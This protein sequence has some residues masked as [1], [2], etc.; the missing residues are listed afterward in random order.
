MSEHYDVVVV[1]AGSA[2][3]PLAVRLAERGRRVALLEAGAHFA[4]L[5]D[6]PRDLRHGG[7]ASV[8]A[9]GHPQSWSFPVELTAAGLTQSLPRGLV[10]GGSSAVNGTIFERALPADLAGWA[11]AGNDLWSFEQL[12]P[13]F[14]RTETDLDVHDEWHGSDGP[15]RVS[16]YAEGDWTASDH[17][18]VDACLAAGFPHDP[19][20]NAPSS[21]GVGPLVMNN[22]DGI[23]QNA[24]QCYLEPALAEHAHLMLQADCLAR[25]VVFDGRRAV[26]VEVERAG[27]RTVVHGD[28]IVLAAGA[29]KSPH[30]LL[31]S[32]VGPADHLRLHGLDVVCD[33][34][35]V[36]RNFT[37]HCVAPLT[38]RAG[39]QATLDPELHAVMHVGLHHTAEG[40][41][42]E[43]DLFSFPSA[44][45][46]NVALLHGVSPLRR[47]RMGLESMRAMSVRRVLDEARLGSSLSLAVIL[48]RPHARGEIALESADPTAKPRIR[49]RYLEHDDDLRR[50]RFGVRLMAS[51][52]QE[53]D[54]F[55]RLGAE[56]LAPGREDLASDA[57]LDR[58][59]GRMLATCIHMSGT[60]RMGPDSDGEAVVDQECRVRGVDNLRVVDTSIWPETISRCAN[61]TAVATGERA[62]E[63]F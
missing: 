50:L 11:A 54:A 14:K 38:F 19:D 53:S 7:L 30:L 13:F 23:R 46:H 41:E 58:W 15:I 52:V 2:G 4:R 42:L 1:G 44:N 26:G 35:G 18:F 28:E 40:S 6:Y 62:A 20:M 32:G 61:A 48:M 55:R 47:L 29:V 16:R 60:C 57:A 12:L 27:E 51:L 37:D 3:I 9:A 17:A 39:R 43:G 31:L 34:P 10:V 36:G 59:L 45:P 22:V 56:L 24:A 63:L 21:R 33:S 25:R 49:Y 8:Y 5:E